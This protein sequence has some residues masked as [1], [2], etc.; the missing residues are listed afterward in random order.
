LAVLTVYGAT[1]F[2][3][4][5]VCQHLKARY[6]DSEEKLNWAIGGRSKDKLEKVKAE[7]SLPKDIAVFVADSNDDEALQAMCKQSK[8]LITLVSFPL[9]L[10]TSK[11]NR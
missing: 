5:L 4:K 11:L 1:G 3:G 9:L 8:A 7:L 6:L 2:T 10:H